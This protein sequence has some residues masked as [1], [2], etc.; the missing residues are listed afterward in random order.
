[1]SDCN[2]AMQDIYTLF[3]QD[4]TIYIRYPQYH[5]NIHAQPGSD[6]ERGIF[7]IVAT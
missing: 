1:M 7:E 3:I 4:D 5:R 2:M 6:P